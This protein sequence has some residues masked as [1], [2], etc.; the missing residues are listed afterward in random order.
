MLIFFLNGDL[1]ALWSLVMISSN[2]KKWIGCF[3]FS[4]VTNLLN[5]RK[6][7]LCCNHFDSAL[8]FA[9]VMLSSVVKLNRL[10][11]FL[12]VKWQSTLNGSTYPNPAP[13]TRS[14]TTLKAFCNE[15]WMCIFLLKQG[16][17]YKMKMKKEI[18]HVEKKS[19]S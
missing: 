8:L 14:G 5:Y 12:D 16:E 11:V 15:I 19:H 6:T 1:N 7:Q 10:C 18:R 2:Y 3:L 17:G 13:G 9:V 4:V